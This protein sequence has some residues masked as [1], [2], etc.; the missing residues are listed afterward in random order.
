MSDKLAMLNEDDRRPGEYFKK[1]GDHCV[2]CGALYGIGSAC[3]RRQEGCQGG[4]GE[5]PR[6]S[7]RLELAALLNRH[8]MENGSNTPDFILAEYLTDCLATFDRT[9]AKRDDWKQR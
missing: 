3:S 6:P 5:N 9:M 8:N 2:R 4:R 1:D 7:F